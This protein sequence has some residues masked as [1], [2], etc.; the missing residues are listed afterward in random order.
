MHIVKRLYIIAALILVLGIGA[1]RVLP[2]PSSTGAQASNARPNVTATTPIKH[3][4]MIMMENHTF[5][6]FFGQFPDANGVR[7]AAAPNPMRA[8]F[9]HSGPALAAILK[10]GYPGRGKVQ[11]SQ[12]DIPNYWAYAQQF[13]LGDNFFTSIATSS[14]P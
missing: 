13:G 8:D 5:D 14:S 7:L 10:E 2:L 3:V 1:W 9:D 12:A 11:Y 6:N 4:V